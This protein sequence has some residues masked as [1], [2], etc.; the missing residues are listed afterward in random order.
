MLFDKLICRNA[1]IWDEYLHHPFVQK[2]QDE[3]L[4]Y[5]N[6]LFYLKQDY[7][8]LIS[9]ACYFSLLGF[10]ARNISELRFAQEQ[11]NAILN[12]EIT[13]HQELLEYEDF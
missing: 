9:Y 11:L 4:P 3:S 2:L 8:Y 5:E 10:K 1:K 12:A 13:L 7:L 6:F